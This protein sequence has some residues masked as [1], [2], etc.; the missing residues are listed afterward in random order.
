MK[1]QKLSLEYTRII[2]HIPS[3]YPIPPKIEIFPVSNFIFLHGDFILPV[4]SLRQY[5]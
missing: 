3:E 4:T 5:P 2:V 1:E